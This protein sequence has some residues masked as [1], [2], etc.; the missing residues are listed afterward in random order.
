MSEFS[1][2]V[3]HLEA[4]KALVKLDKAAK[5]RAECKEGSGWTR[6]GNK[7]VRAKPKQGK[8]KVG[9]GAIAALGAAAITAGTVGYLYKSGKAKDIAQQAMGKAYTS[10]LDSEKIDENIDNSPLPESVKG[11]LKNL[12]GESKRFLAETY[13]KSSGGEFLGVDESTGITTFKEKDGTIRSFSTNGSSLLVFSSLF[14]E[15]KDGYP[16]Y[17][18]GFTIDEKFERPKGGRK[19]NGKAKDFLQ[20]TQRMFQLHSENLPDY[21]FLKVNAFKKDD[22]GKKRERIYKRMGFSSL[23]MPGDYLWA[24]K[25]E[26]KFSSISPEEAMEVA[27]FLQSRFDSSKGLKNEKTT[28]LLDAL[29]A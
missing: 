12:A 25:R 5:K 4:N 27:A 15:K 24:L 23:P 6:A 14:K 26:G 28:K 16:V 29:L 19:D 17:E 10:L 22:A 7:C 11:K 13:L 3:G 20:K 21:A 18:M 8:V 2:A 9:K 1:R